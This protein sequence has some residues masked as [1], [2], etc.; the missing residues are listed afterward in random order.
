MHEE[1]DRDEQSGARAQSSAEGEERRV[2]DE[3][4]RVSA[5]AG[6]SVAK[7]SS[8]REEVWRRAAEMSSGGEAMRVAVTAVEAP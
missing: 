4:M 3:E 1:R 6:L 7:A 5:A 8:I 2:A